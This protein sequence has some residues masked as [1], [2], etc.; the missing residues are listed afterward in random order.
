[1]PTA[2]STPARG[3]SSGYLW[4]VPGRPLYVLLSGNAARALL[5]SGGRRFGRGEE[6]GGVLL[7]RVSCED[8]KTLVSVEQCVGV[9]SEHLFG[10]RYS[11]SEA[12]KELCQEVV[13]ESARGGSSLRAVGFYR[14]HK[15]KG[16]GLDSDDLALMQE[17]FPDP[18]CVALVVK[19]RFPGQSRAGFFI[20]ENGQIR[21]EA[22]HREF[23]LRAAGGTKP[24][25][26]A[27]PARPLWSSW[28][29]QAPLL[30]CLFAAD[31][32]LGYASARQ[33][34]QY[35]PATPPAPDPYSLSLL[36]LEYVD[37]LHL[38]WDRHARPI[39]NGGNGLL[40]IIDGGQTRTLELSPDQLK[41]GSVIYR[42]M[43]AQVRFRLEVFLKGGRSVSETWDSSLSAAVSK[44]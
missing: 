5:K 12:D 39:E 23:S 31:A 41:S 4:Q 21:S 28:W 24:G 11:L 27:H 38:T 36:V 20:W 16:L 37:N 26:D 10:P 19:R 15:R 17:L 3:A 1:M 30:L 42:R 14:T 29:L 44:R 40:H 25:K 35:R 32:L 7:G 13:T 34:N 22:S 8:G 2:V 43:T 18:E 33:W 6:T 9:P